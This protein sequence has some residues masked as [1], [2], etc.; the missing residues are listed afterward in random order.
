MPRMDKGHTPSADAADAAGSAPQRSASRR[1]NPA[2]ILAGWLWPV[3]F[4]GWSLRQR[5]LFLCEYASPWFPGED[6]PAWKLRLPAVLAVLLAAAALRLTG[7]ICREGDAGVIAATIF[8]LSPV[9]Y[10]CGVTANLRPEPWGFI[11]GTLPWWAFLPSMIREI[12][13]A[14]V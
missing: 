10:A 9:V 7:R 8:L 12:G 5:P 11:V 6:L 3:A 13:R 2:L 1:R 14:H 4:Y